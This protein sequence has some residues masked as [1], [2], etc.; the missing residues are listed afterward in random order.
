MFRLTAQ[1]PGINIISDSAECL[2]IYKEGALWEMNKT[3]LTQRRLIGDVQD[4]HPVFTSG[5]NRILN[6]N[7]SLTV[8]QPD[9]TL[10]IIGGRL[11]P[12][13]QLG[14][15]LLIT[16]R[17]QRPNQL[18]RLNAAGKEVWRKDIAL[19]NQH[20]IVGDK[21]YYLRKDSY[22][23]RFNI[24][25]RLSL[26]TGEHDELIDFD[27]GYLD[28]VPDKERYKNAFYY[29]LMA[30]EEVIVAL[31]NNNRIVAVDIHTGAVKWEITVVTDAKGHAAVF[32]FAGP[33]WGGMFDGKRY[34]LQGRAFSYIDPIS[35]S[36][37]VLQ[38]PLLDNTGRELNVFASRKEGE[39]L[40]YTASVGGKDLNC[41]GVFDVHQ[42]AVIWQEEVPIAPRATLRDAPLA[43]SRYLFVADSNNVLYI[44]EQG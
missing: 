24:I 12:D 13:V 41:I 32:P 40:L 5:N 9:G 35:Q 2:Y 25:N 29:L 3:D 22:N 17:S 27:P 44:Y 4:C 23:V 39:Q 37:V 14:E 1:L 21:L 10:Q 8:L 34:V 15:D 36:A 18:I 42:E 16:D 19:G 26:A 30:N 6:C 38:Y 33:V 20:L 11:F 7:G 43:G 28:K 31:V